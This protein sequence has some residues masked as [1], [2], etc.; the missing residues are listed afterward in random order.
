MNEGKPSSL[1]LGGNCLFQLLSPT[2]SLSVLN[3]TSSGAFSSLIQGT[4]GGWRQL[5]LQ[6]LPWVRDTLMGD[7]AGQET[8]GLRAENSKAEGKWVVKGAAWKSWQAAVVSAPLSPQP[9]ALFVILLCSL[10]SQLLPEAQQV[11]PQP[12]GLSPSGAGQV[13]PLSFPFLLSLSLLQSTG[14]HSSEPFTP[15]HCSVGY[16]RP[17]WTCWMTPPMHPTDLGKAA[18]A[19]RHFWE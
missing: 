18:A 5:G 12:R 14:T 11:V 3:S 7:C 19:S 8:S 13:P 6:N 15:Q 2:G 17:L 4:T 1:L 10:E 9:G 16:L